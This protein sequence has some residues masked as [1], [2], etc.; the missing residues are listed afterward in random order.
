MN[1][2]SLAYIKAYFQTGKYQYP[3]AGLTHFDKENH[4]FCGYRFP[5]D[6]PV[7]FQDGLRLTCRVGEKM[8]AKIFH[9]PQE[10]TYWTCT[11]VYEW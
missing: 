6:D 9:N 8:G 4:S 10:T 11:W 3:L 7:F 2:F 1:L 5:D